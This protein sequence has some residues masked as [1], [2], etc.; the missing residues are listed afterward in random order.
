MDVRTEQAY[1]QRIAALE[2]QNASLESR[3]TDLTRQLAQRDA[4]IGAGAILL[5]P[6]PPER[7][8]GP[9]ACGGSTRISP[10]S[11]SLECPVPSRNRHQIG[12]IGGCIG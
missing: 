3:V 2:L 8:S 12:F 5:P 4:T 11:S 10:L 1:Q 9:G 7:S 6:H